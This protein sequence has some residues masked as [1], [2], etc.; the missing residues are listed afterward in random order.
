MQLFFEAADHVGEV[1]GGLSVLG[2][3]ALLGLQ[4][5]FGKVLFAQLGAAQLAGHDVHRQ[6]LVV[7]LVALIELVHHGDVLHQRQLV[8]FQLGRDLID[9]LFGLVVLRLERSDVLPRFFEEAHEALFLLGLL[10]IEP[11]QLDDQVGELLADLAHVLGAHFAQGGVRKI[12][13]VLLRGGAVVQYLL[14]VGD[15]DLLGKLAHGGLLGGGEAVDIQLFRGGL[16]LFLRRERGLRRGGDRRCCR[17]VGV[18]RK[19]GDEFFV[20]VHVYSSF[21]S[22]GQRRSAPPS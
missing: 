6:L 20:L 22:C 15:V 4:L 17:S 8:L 13:D 18:E 16:G 1:V 11:L 12:G 3:A 9:V 19:G 14:G 10:K 21:L 5:G 7:L 2:Q